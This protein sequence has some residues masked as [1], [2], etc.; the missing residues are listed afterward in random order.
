MT[1]TEIGRRYV[2]LCR[3]GKRGEVIDTLFAKDVVSVE[4]VAPPGADRAA[5]GLDAVRGKSKWWAEN[6][7]LH[8][9][10]LSGP[11]L[12]TTA[13]RCASCSTSRTS[14]AASER[15]WTRSGSSPSWTARS[16]GKRSSIR[17]A[18]VVDTLVGAIGCAFGAIRFAASDASPARLGSRTPS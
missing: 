16:P 9:A 3:E 17:S 11:Y 13:S 2:A 4:A 15:R 8:K 18:D 1:T 7:T 14:K 12:T 10:E 5:K 6:N